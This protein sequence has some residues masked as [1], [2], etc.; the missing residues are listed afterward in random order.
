[1]GSGDQDAGLALE[2]DPELRRTRHDVVA[3]ADLA[4]EQPAHELPRGLFRC[5]LRR[6]DAAELGRDERRDEP[7]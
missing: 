6:P 2:L 1:M 3:P 7:Q 4:R 5:P